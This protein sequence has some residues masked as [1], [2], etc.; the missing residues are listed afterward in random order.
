MIKHSMTIGL[1]IVALAGS[2]TNCKTYAAQSEVASQA[3]QAI[4]YAEA[5]V[6]KARE[7]IELGKQLITQIPEDHL[8]MPDVAQ[9]LELASEN[10]KTAVDSLKGAEMSA[11]K[12]G[13]ATQDSIAND[14][15]MLAKVN[16]GVSVSGAKVVQMSITYLDAIANNKTGSLR[17]IRAAMQDAL[18]SSSQ[19]QLSYERVKALISQ[20]YSK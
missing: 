2:V 4:E 6:E 9:V 20:K 15:A 13:S 3:K 14:Y 17:I 8:L 16:A 18:E 7:A 10:W 11:S 19:V 12:M 1:V 5:E